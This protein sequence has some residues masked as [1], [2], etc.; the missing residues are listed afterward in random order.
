[1][2]RNIGPSDLSELAAMDC[3]AGV[4]VFTQFTLAQRWL[5]KHP[6]RQMTRAFFLNWLRRC[7]ARP[8]LP[9]SPSFDETF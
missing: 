6:K 8:T 4:D 7:P 3:F 9:I 5:L 2:A 1:M